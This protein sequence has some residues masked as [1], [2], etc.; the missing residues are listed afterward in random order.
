[1]LAIIAILLAFT[2]PTLIRE[3]DH[4]VAREEADVLKTFG[5]A[6]QAAV[7]RHAYIPSHTNWAEMVAEEAGFHPAAV[8][9]NPRRQPRLLL[10]D[11]NGWFN[12]VS[13]SY[14]QSAAG[15]VVAPLNARMMIISSLGHALPLSAGRLSSS[16]FNAL[17]QAAEGTTNFPTTGLWSGWG[18]RADDVKIERVNLTSLFV[19]L[20]LETYATEPA[21]GQYAIGAGGITPAPY[22]NPTNITVAR[23]YL[24]GTMLHL[25]NSTNLNSA[26]DSRQLLTQDSWYLYQNQVWRN[27]GGG[28]SLPGG[29]DISGVVLGFLN[30]V[31]NTRARYGADQQRLVVGAMMNYMSNYNTWAEG[32]FTDNTLKSYL[33]NTVQPNMYATF[34]EIFQGSYYPTNASGPK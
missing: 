32:G 2:L 6:L 7:K 11:T 30:A 15:S 12:W 33:L 16:E 24:Q 3:T 22:Q 23:Y 31:P 4:R 19:S 10:I 25:Y 13:L 27:S 1:M 8:T 20:G 34:Q 14:T 29:V 18:G 17:W 28:G 9:T 5:N 21:P 26:L